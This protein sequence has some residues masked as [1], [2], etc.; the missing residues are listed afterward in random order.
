M[1]G[2]SLVHEMTFWEWLSE[3]FRRRSAVVAPERELFEPIDRDAITR[4]LRLVECGSERGRRNQPA[5]DDDAPDWVE[6]KVVE[7][8]D[9]LRLHAASTYRKHA[10]VYADFLPGLQSKPFVVAALAKIDTAISDIRTASSIG[11]DVL[12]TARERTVETTREFAAFRTKNCLL[13]PAR[14]PPSHA[15]HIGTLL[16]LVVIES[17]LNGTLLAQ[18]NVYGEI[19]GIVTAFV[20]AALNLAI[21]FIAGR[22]GA[23]W[24]RHINLAARTVGRASLVGYVPTLTVFNLSIAHYRAALLSS[25]PGQGLPPEVV[26]LQTLVRTPLSGPDVV[27]WIL[28]GM[29]CLFSVVAAFDGGHWDDPY[30]G[31]GPMTRRRDSAREEYAGGKESMLTELSSIRSNANAEA[32]LELQRLDLRERERQSLQVAR[33][34]LDQKYSSHA[35][36]LQRALTELLDSYREANRQSRTDPAP[37]HFARLH[38]L[39]T[40]ELYAPLEIETP[41][42]TR[43]LQA[44]FANEL[45]EKMK[46]LDQEYSEALGALEDIDQ[47]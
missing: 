17:L 12:F 13:R 23:S 6:R 47:L 34:D 28:F 2:T 37:V 35:A 5:S 24:A 22:F 9:D 16:L 45:G 41:E 21:G 39:P 18:G 11:K 38:T 33:Q 31:Y 15:L 10:K 29:G 26:A 44:R 20:I 30:P 46:L 42:T 32:Q 27:G 4:R 3:K 43:E 19:G 40:V 14:I 7:T 25:V 36:L 8:I 1:L